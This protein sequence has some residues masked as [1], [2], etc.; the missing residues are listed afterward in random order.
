MRAAMKAAMRRAMKAKKSVIAKGKMAKS[1][2]FRGTKGGQDDISARMRAVSQAR[3]DSQPVNTRT[4][5]S[6]FKNPGG[7]NPNGS[8]AW[9]LIDQAGCRGLVRGGA[10]VSELHCNFLIN[11]GEATA[12]DLEALGEEVRRRVQVHSGI[13]LQ[14]EIRIIGE[15]GPDYVPELIPEEVAS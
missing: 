14:W 9:E 13:M 3:K 11:T 10:Q 15:H 5:G 7:E 6:T 2:V 8:K 4:G 1:V 12:A